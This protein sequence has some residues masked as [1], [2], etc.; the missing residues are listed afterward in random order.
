MGKDLRLAAI[1][2]YIVRSGIPGATATRK[3]W[4]PTAK[5]MPKARASEADTDDDSDDDD[6]DDDATD[7]DT[8]DESDEDQEDS[9]SESDADDDDDA[10]DDD[11]SE[12]DSKPKSRKKPGFKVPKSQAELDELIRARLDRKA[13]EVE[14]QVKADLKREQQLAAAKKR[15][16]SDKV[17]KALEEEIEKLKEANKE[18]SLVEIKRRVAQKAG[19]PPSAAERLIGK[20]EAE[21]RS[22]AKALKKE[23]GITAKPVKKPADDRG[24]SNRPTGSKTSDE[25]ADWKKPE[26]WITD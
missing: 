11:E 15:G 3:S 24:E 5:G 7:A 6:D 12:D 17:I 14:A 13:R 10:E 8:D 9:E 1:E 4:Q 25:Q 23:L 22:D 16:D 2:S 20:N 18:T 21:L 19:L 26:F